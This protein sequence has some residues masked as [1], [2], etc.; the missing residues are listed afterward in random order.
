MK[1]RCVLKHP[2]INIA[3]KTFK[4]TFFQ[5]SE[6]T[7]L[8]RPLPLAHV[9]WHSC[10]HGDPGERWFQH[11]E[12]TSTDVLGSSVTC[13]LPV[14]LNIFEHWQSPSKLLN[15]PNNNKQPLGWH[16]MTPILE[17]AS[18]QLLAHRFST[19]IG[20]CQNQKWSAVPESTTPSFTAD[21]PKDF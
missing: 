21:M 14:T 16:E 18:L 4:N 7:P 20:T 9:R 12:W 10:S 13:L 19:K 8:R 1:L 2:N 3:I 17:L 5:E 6:V 11:V 15:S